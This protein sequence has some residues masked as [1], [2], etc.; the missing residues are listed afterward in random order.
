MTGVLA[1]EVA[2]MAEA[3]VMAATR[4]AVKVAGARVM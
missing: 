4:A 1:T 2:E 3:T